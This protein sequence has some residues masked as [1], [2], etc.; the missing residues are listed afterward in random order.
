MFSYFAGVRMRG[1]ESLRAGGG[2]APP[3]RVTF[4][5][6]D[7]TIVVFIRSLVYTRR[8]FLLTRVAHVCTYG[9]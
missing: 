7:F 4:V 9:A 6:T 3:F 1:A 2:G 8:N 5:G